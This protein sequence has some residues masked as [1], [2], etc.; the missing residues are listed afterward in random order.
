MVSWSVLDPRTSDSWTIDIHLPSSSSGRVV[1]VWM[2]GGIF[3]DWEGAMFS[4]F[5]VNGTNMHKQTHRPLFRELFLN[6]LGLWH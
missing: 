5:R 3:T 6:L 2:G 1:D 4:G